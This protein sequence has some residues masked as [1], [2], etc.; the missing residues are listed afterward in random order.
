[1]GMIDSIV[2]HL[3]FVGSPVP[4]KTAAKLYGKTVK[5]MRSWV[6]NDPRLDI[7]DD[8]IVL[9]PLV[10]SEYGL[11]PQR[12]LEMLRNS[13]DPTQE[14]IEQ[15]CREVQ[16]TWSDGIREAR[17]VGGRGVRSLLRLVGHK[18]KPPSRTRFSI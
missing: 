7:V 11:I 18:V 1:M 10:E 12:E 15:R 4:L 16:R 17:W 14:E 5:A 3:W 9:S 13:D 8:M 2:C 6:L